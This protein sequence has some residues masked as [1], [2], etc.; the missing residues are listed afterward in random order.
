MLPS[1]VRVSL[2]C[3]LVLL[4]I[5]PTPLAVEGSELSAMSSSQSPS[6]AP[7]LFSVDS[8]L[9]TVAQ[10][11]RANNS[12]TIQH[13]DPSNVDT[14]GDTAALQQWFTRRLSS[15]LENSTRNL[16]QGEYET[17]RELLGDEYNQTLSRYVDLAEQT[18]DEGD[19][20]AAERYQNTTTQHRE[21]VSTIEKYQ[22]TREAYLDAKENGNETR[23]RKLAR[24]L[25]QLYTELNETS[26]NLIESY[27]ALGNV[28]GT[29]TSDI[30]RSIAASTTNIST[31]QTEIRETEFT[32]TTLTIEHHTANI[33]FRTPLEVSGHLRS[34]N[35]TALANQ[36]IAVQLGPQQ[37]VT[38]T[39]TNGS[40]TATARPTR[41][42]RG[43]QSVSIRY[44]PEDQSVYLGTMTSIAVDV[45]AVTPTVTLTRIP[46]E[47]RFNQTVS[48]TG[49]VGVANVTETPADVPV[50]VTLGSTALGTTTTNA[51]GVFTLD[52][53][54]LASVPTG[55]QELRAAIQLEDRSLR[56]AETTESLSVV[57]T[58]T[59]LSVKTVRQS[60]THVRFEGMLETT[61]ATPV[62]N[63][64][65]AL[66][67]DGHTV[68]TVRTNESGGYSTVLNTSNVT[69]LADSSTANVTMSF[70]G[71]GNLG[72]S[73]ATTSFE[74]SGGRATSFE[75]SGGRDLWSQ[76]PVIPLVLGGSI[77]GLGILGGLVLRTRNGTTQSSTA[78][79]T[80][81][82][83]DSTPDRKT[84]SNHAVAI[85]QT[86]LEQATHR[87]ENEQYDDA[88]RIAY[89]ASRYQAVSR[90]EALQNTAAHTHWE[91]YRAYHEHEDE[92][93]SRAGEFKSLTELFEHAQ[94]GTRQ[95]SAEE[96]TTAVETATDIVTERPADT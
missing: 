44:L 77:L 60:A 61:T 17:A 96:A 23:A 19:D 9:E 65:V 37:V 22:N 87:L 2:C 90:I 13:E 56:P 15:Q 82:T 16:S 18:S 24:E 55:T 1:G 59:Q 27:D 62:A 33:S 70:T 64:M 91:F 8:R 68:T 34:A 47:A 4:V 92:T 3:L 88:I 85:E 12:S 28:T 51:S 21:Y 50:R 49:R 89:Q 41:A 5:A 66:Q 81:V 20:Q 25:E 14:E 35:G 10:Q 75:T 86:L 29:N 76:L 73:T 94:F 39:T 80:Q 54:F 69:Q 63:Q 93:R 72:A 46:D 84:D 11:T 78:E 32:E 83:T 43:T 26:T 79:P 57:E 52:T 38:T 36:R 45:S 58:P 95:I 42:P 6:S 31:Q 71:T 7:A 30:Q 74:T 48:I 53:T 40:F 67:V